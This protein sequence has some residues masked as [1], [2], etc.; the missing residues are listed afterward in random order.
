MVDILR[1]IGMIDRALDSIANIEF[2]KV[3]LARGQYLYLVRIYE[4]PG[5]I[6]EQLS[7]LIKVDRTTIARAVKKLEAN[8]LI[9][10]RRDPDNKKIKHLYVTA[11]G[12][13]VYPFIIR[14]N[15]HSNAVALKGF[16][17]KEAQ[18]LHD[19]LRRARHNIDGDWDFV[20]HGGKR[21]Y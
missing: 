13:Q 6:S 11:K 5:I 16:T 17:G 9:E 18:Q 15:E 3:D 10:R 14:E 21:K 2:K 19:F 4:H 1:E 12:K 8:G 7:N 20:K